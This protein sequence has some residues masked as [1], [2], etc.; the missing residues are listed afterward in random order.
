[1]RCRLGSY[2]SGVLSRARSQDKRR[3]IRSFSGLLSFGTVVEICSFCGERVNSVPVMC[4]HGHWIYICVG[5]F[6][7][8]KLACYQIPKEMI[9]K[10]E[11]EDCPCYRIIAEKLMAKKD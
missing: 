1:M 8:K 2:S 10:I 5:C 6:E 4:S 3:N 9:P 11:L 7:S